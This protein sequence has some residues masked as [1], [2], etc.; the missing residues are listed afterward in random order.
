MS[1]KYLETI[2]AVD[3]SVLNLE[4]HQWR[5]ERTL[6]LSNTHSLFKQLT[7]PTKGIYRCRVVYDEN[8]IDIEYIKY[9]RRQVNTLKIVI[10]DDIDYTRKYENRDTINE[11]FALRD[12]CDDILIVKSGLV[13]DTSI[14]NIAFYDGSRWITPKRPLLFGTTRE[15]YINKGVLKEEDIFVDDISKYTKVALLN[16]MIDFDI[17]SEENIE[18]TI[19]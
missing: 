1:K 16:A 3:G 19:C 9:F 14:A 17:M 5:L 2:K 8:S 11:L 6:S 13:T 12:K 18:D 15:R 4:Y 7:P 10:S